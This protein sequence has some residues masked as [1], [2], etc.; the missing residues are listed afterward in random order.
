MAKLMKPDML[1]DIQM[2][3]YG[4]F[5]FDKSEKLIAI[6]RQKTALAISKYEGASN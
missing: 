1:V 4:S 3:R 2:T 5:D 6:G